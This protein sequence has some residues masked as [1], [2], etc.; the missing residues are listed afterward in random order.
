MN[1]IIAFLL[2]FTICISIP[3]HGQDLLKGNDL[4]AVVVDDLSDV[5]I[6]ELQSQLSGKNM[7]IDQVEP[8]ALSKG[9][10]PSEFS[11]LRAR[12]QALKPE[13]NVSTGEVSA[14]D[15][16]D[17]SVS[18]KNK[19]SD[20]PATIKRSNP[21]IF[22]SELFNNAALSFEPN[23]KLA[24]PLNYTLGPDDELQI[25]VYGVQE[26]NASLKV[27]SEGKISI[28]YVGQIS[29]SGMTIEAATQKIKSAMS[30]V[31]STVASGQST[32]TVSLSRI[33]TIRVT[34]IGSMQP[35]NYAVSS[36][37]TVYNALHLAGGP[38]ENGSYRNIELIR[39]N[40]IFKS[41]DIYRFL[42]NGDQSDDVG[43]KDN[44]VIRIPIYRNR[45]K[46]EGEVKRA[47]I[48][49]MKGEETF[50]DLLGFASGFSEEAYTASV[51]VVQ[52]TDKEYKIKDILS[53]EFLTYK[54][55]SG[56][57][58]K[59]SKILSR[60]ENRI[61][62]EGAVFRPNFYSF[63]TGMKVSDLV[64]KA[65]GIR[66]D[67][68]TKRARIVRVKEDL[69]TEMVE[70]DLE[71]ALA[72]DATANIELKKED[73]LTIYSLLD[74]KENFKITIDGEIKKPGTYDY[75][76][77]LSLN[78]LL[79]EAGG[80]TGAASK[81]VEIARML[82]SEDVDKDGKKR[83][84]VINLEINVQNNEQLENIKLF[85]FD[86]INIRKLP[87]YEHP[88]MVVIKGEVNYPGKYVLANK[89]E[90]I[91]DV[92]TKAGGLT[93]QAN[94]D[95]VKIK[96]PIKAEQIEDL[97]R[98]DLNLGKGDS[99]QKDLTDKVIKLKYA[100]IPVDWQKIK[101]NKNHY[102]NIMLL[103]GDEIEVMAYDE[104]VKISGNVLLTSEIPYRKGKGFNYYLDAVGG[105]D[106]KGWKRKSY[107][108]YPNGKAATS[109]SFLFFRS[110]PDVEPGSQI[111]VPAKPESK[112]M[113]TAEVVTIASVLTSLAGV[114]IAILR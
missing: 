35:G 24:T 41:I 70:V 49:E 87:V 64:S 21:Q 101:A 103:P 2:F 97:D 22:G 84:E 104:A 71:K 94:I 11:K 83:V 55:L 30:K 108:I 96:R 37:S 44:D 107:I 59:V 10:S 34:I 29:V 17:P 45:V 51:N 9:M 74:F 42:I 78:D 56:D 66:E 79:I 75:F 12:L 102:S 53:S 91:Y 28:P 111:V 6:A 27:S 26:F 72:G 20:S 62:I 113:S 68:Y 105:L 61:T 46:L 25:S 47:G 89:E 32:V 88:E 58:Y 77:N 40:K 90:R 19:L 54:P 4:K 33:R 93:N 92:I 73:I 80:L 38:A 3:V 65:E 16:K 69:T 114:I 85:P 1:K 43:L 14:G 95:G 63:F 86:V 50:F 76:E 99:I 106:N 57:V 18:K 36:L 39:N 82:K 23:L 5:Q 13:A 52:K 110:Y 31:Y 112:K 98:I 60:Y 8:M 7:T 48:F 15:S 109:S 67:A 81:K 100:T